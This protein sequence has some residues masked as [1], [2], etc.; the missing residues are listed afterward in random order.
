MS[1]TY[2]AL[3]DNICGEFKTFALDYRT[4]EFD[5]LIWMNELYDC[6][7]NLSALKHVR[8]EKGLYTLKGM[9]MVNILNTIKT[10]RL[11][12]SMG[13]QKYF[14]V[15]TDKAVNPVNMMG[16]SKRIMEI[17]LMRESLM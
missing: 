13:A 16:S 15:S 9:I 1:G 8:S 4:V 14:C 5:A 2:A 3:W 10:V 7:F 6:I 12:K 11:T 17:I